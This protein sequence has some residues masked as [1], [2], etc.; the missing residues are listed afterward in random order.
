[1]SK[2]GYI[3]ASAL[4]ILL[5]A[6]VGSANAQ[7]RVLV[8]SDEFDG[9]AKSSPDSSK[10]SFDTGGGGWGNNEMEY[11]TSRLQNAFINGKGQ[12]KIM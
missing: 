4:C 2:E 9:P 11:Y 10:W 6:S 5:F 3:V 1:M 7:E 8:W 12:L